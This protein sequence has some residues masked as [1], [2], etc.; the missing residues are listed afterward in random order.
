MSELRRGAY[1]ALSAGGV[2]AEDTGSAALAVRAVSTTA[3]VITQQ[4]A[5][6]GT[7]FPSSANA[8]VA[9]A[10]VAEMVVARGAAIARGDMVGAVPSIVADPYRAEG[11]GLGGS[12][13]HF[14]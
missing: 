14:K 9:Q 7:A 2:A 4:S 1:S 3:S 5:P 10:R 11:T 8:S 12:V 13:Q 6:I